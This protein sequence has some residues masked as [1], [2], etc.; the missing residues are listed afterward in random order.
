MVSRHIN[1]R[2]FFLGQFHVIFPRPLL[3]RPYDQ[4]EEAREYPDYYEGCRH[5][6]IFSFQYFNTIS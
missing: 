4:K 3:Q 1:T 5:F 6:S 2:I